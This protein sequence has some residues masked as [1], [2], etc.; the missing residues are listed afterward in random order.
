MSWRVSP[1]GFVHSSCVGCGVDI[2]C[3]MVSSS[4]GS[5]RFPFRLCDACLS[6][7]VLSSFSSKSGVVE[8]SGVS[9]GVGKVPR[10]NPVIGGV[11]ARRERSD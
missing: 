2:R 9:V 7:V 11:F 5:G 1:G 4:S 6:K 8:P 10:E 3:R